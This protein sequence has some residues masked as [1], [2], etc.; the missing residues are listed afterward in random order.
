M[1]EHN[2]TLAWRQLV[3][4]RLQSAVSVVS[5]AIGF[6]CFALASMWIKYETTYDAFHKDAENI[7]CLI[8]EDRV[9]SAGR[10]GWSSTIPVT[11]SI[12]AY[13]PE[14]NTYTAFYGADIR[15]LVLAD[16]DSIAIRDIKA[17]EC[18]KSFF[19]FFSVKFILGDS[20]F[21][22]AISVS[23]APVCNSALLSSASFVL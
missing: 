15:E 10:P 13:C 7:Y 8:R 12:I 6:A 20:D 9:I 4:Y 17:L 21:L 19:D 5:L 2:L 22:E 14:I 18:D 1:I 11:D 23:S 16:N 3:K